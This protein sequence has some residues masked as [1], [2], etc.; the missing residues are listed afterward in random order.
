MILKKFWNKLSKKWFNWSVGIAT[1]V[2]CMITCIG[3]NRGIQQMSTNLNQFSL[4]VRPVIEKYQSSR[5]TLVYRDV[6]LIS[7][8]TVVSVHKDTVYLHQD[9]F[10]Y[11]TEGEVRKLKKLMDTLEKKDPDIFY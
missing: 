1:I 5:D 7:R 3:V 6:I 9:V 4:D 8:D 11:V 10:K 2:S